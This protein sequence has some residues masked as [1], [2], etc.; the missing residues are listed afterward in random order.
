MESA[1]TS[2]YL[3][4]APSISM[5]VLF[6]VVAVC[7][8]VVIALAAEGKLCCAGCGKSLESMCGDNKTDHMKGDIL[9]RIRREH[10]MGETSTSVIRGVHGRRRS[11]NK[12]DVHQ[13][14]DRNEKIA[15]IQES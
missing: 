4:W 6:A 11:E 15:A 9:G 3:Q 14:L 12:L 10:M 1:K 8:I 2:D 5:G 13:M 7:I